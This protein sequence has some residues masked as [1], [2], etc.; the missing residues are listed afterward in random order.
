M[1]EN[2]Q[3]QNGQAFDSKAQHQSA[4]VLH[5]FILYS[6]V[7]FCVLFAIGF[8]Y[9]HFIGRRKNRLPDM[10]HSSTTARF[11][12]ELAQQEA[13]RAQHQSGTIAGGTV[14]GTKTVRLGGEA[15]TLLSRH[16]ESS[17]SGDDDF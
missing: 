10:P 17:D 1:E 11:W 8:V 7:T 2:E 15:R 5:T 9:A 12:N 3:Q 13:G 6:T 14:G 16:N 4:D